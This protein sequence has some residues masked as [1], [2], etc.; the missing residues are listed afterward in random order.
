[1]KRQRY[2]PRLLAQRPEWH[3]NL[4]IKLPTVA[5]ALPLD[6]D[7]VNQG[8]G[9]NL[10]MAYGL[11]L[12]LTTVRDF[13]PACTASL[14]EL[15]DGAGD[16]AF[17][18]PVFTAPTPPT[19]P[20]GIT[21]KPGA[22]QRIF[23]LVQ[24]IKSKPGYTEAMGIDLGIVGPEDTVEITVP[25]FSMKLEQGT[26]CQCV[27]LSFKKHGWYAVAIYSRRGN[28][29][30]VLLGIDSES[31]YLDERPLLVPGQPEVREYRM[32]YWEG[33]TE[34]GEWTAVQSIT[35]GV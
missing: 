13:A 25:E 6:T 31:P 29:E 26:G 34:Q 35:V 10:T 14:R 12:W 28:G 4:A 16:S 23:R 27:R 5:A 7:V 9:D 22:L 21:V 32:R 18:F 24:D 8:V 19:L 30:W 15:E 2:Y 20:V 33:G 17:V 11:G 3:E 1:M